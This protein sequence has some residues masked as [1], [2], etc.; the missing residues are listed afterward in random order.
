MRRLLASIGLTSSVG[1]SG[2]ATLVHGT[3][4]TIPV[5]SLPP[6]ARVSVDGVLVGVA[7]LHVKVSRKQNHVVSITHDSLP[8]VHIALERHLSMWVLGNLWLYIVPA[9]VDF[10]YG[11]AYA[12]SRDTIRTESTSGAGADSSAAAIPTARI[13]LTDGSRVTAAAYSALV[14]FGL[15][16]EMLGIGAAGKPFRYAQ[17]GSLIG[18]TAG[19]GLGFA[20]HQSGEVVFW[21]SA[22]AFVGARFLET[23]NVLTRPEELVVGA[24]TSVGRDVSVVPLLDRRGPGAALRITF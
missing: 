21:G 12:F 7:P 13:R 22:A 8:P 2:C 18:A 16:H 9:G 3:G 23:A 11:G 24:R 1:L 4:Q 5:A 6:G 14:G 19:L 17:V 20:G 15:G 10:E